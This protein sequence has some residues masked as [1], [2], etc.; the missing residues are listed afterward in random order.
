MSSAAGGASAAVV[1][2]GSSSDAPVDQSEIIRV[3]QNMMSQKEQL[4]AK[5]SELAV[6]HAEYKRVAESLK[7]MDG[8]RRCYQLLNGVLVERTVGEVAPSVAEN[9][10]SLDQVV[11]SMHE[12]L[13]KLV[14]EMKVYQQ[15]FNRASNARDIDPRRLA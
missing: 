8:G 4:T 12:R 13:G 5:I 15:R 7:T 3:F 9:R 6:E 11:K 2:G 10:D 14:E 1:S